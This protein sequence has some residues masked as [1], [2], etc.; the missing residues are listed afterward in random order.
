VPLC[1]LAGLGSNGDGARSSE[2]GAESGLQGT[3]SWSAP[4][5]LPF[6]SCV[7]PRCLSNGVFADNNGNG[8]SNDN[9]GSNGNS[10]NIFTFY[11]L[12]LN[13]FQ[14]PSPLPFSLPPAAAAEHKHTLTRTWGN[15]MK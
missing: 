8:N 6:A 15:G 12:R 11:L 3:G 9:N 1:S 14:L 10:S 2:L 7:P 5:P 13:P 4:L